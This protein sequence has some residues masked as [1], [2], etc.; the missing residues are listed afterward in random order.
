M[1]TTV[2]AKIDDELDAALDR[3]ASAAGTPKS[4]VI[5]AAVRAFVESDEAFVAAVDEGLAASRAGHLV[6]HEQVVASIESIVGPLRS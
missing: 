6:D 4:A 1:A 2:T 5:A 3:I